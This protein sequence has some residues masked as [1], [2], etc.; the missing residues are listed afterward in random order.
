MGARYQDRLLEYALTIAEPKQFAKID[1][2]QENL[3]KIHIESSA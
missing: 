2:K 1:K 3:Y